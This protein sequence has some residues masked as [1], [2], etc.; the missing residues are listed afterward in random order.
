M[1]TGLKINET[2]LF[3]TTIAGFVDRH[4][5]RK[6]T[7]FTSDKSTWQDVIVQANFKIFLTTAMAI[8]NKQRQY[9]N[10]PNGHFIQT[11]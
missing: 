1:I 5:N 4:G 3:S 2:R 6:G 9:S 10:T 11:N 7:T 8:V